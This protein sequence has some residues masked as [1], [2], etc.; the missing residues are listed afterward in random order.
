MWK[1]WIGW[2][3]RAFVFD[4]DGPGMTSPITNC[5]ETADQ[6]PKLKTEMVTLYTP[7][8]DWSFCHHP[9]ISFFDGRFYATWSN[10]FIHEDDY[11]QRMMF[12]TAE[13]FDQWSEPEVLAG[14]PPSKHG[15]EPA[16]L[17][18]AGM[19]VADGSLVAYYGLYD[20]VH[21]EFRYVEGKEHPDNLSTRDGTSLWARTTTDGEQWTEAADLNCPI[22][23]N[24]GPEKLQ[25]GRLIISGNTMFPYTDDPR[26][27]AGWT[28]AGIYPQEMAEGMIDEPLTFEKV[29]KKA[30][31]PVPLCE[32]SFYQ[33]DDGAITMM[34]RSTENR[35]WVSHSQDDGITWTT[36]APTNFTD[37]I[38]KMHFGR[39]P[40]G[41]FY[42][43]GC[44]DPEPGYTRRRL[45][46][47]LS[48]DGIVFD[49][50]YILADEPFE[51]ILP[52]RY[53]AGIYGYGHTM[54][55][56]D[57]CLYVIFSICKEQI[58][59][60]RTACELDIL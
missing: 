53:K 10:G 13:R 15:T 14:P 22:I 3:N 33:K 50:S 54:L 26:G 58:A 7:Q 60:V 25:S 4:G 1:F 5:Y 43:V 55:N 2:G 36:P 48:D 12:S 51:M 18:A 39:W 35:L 24:L 30:G 49:R 52:G 6:W 21:G 29:S 19:H 44:P 46:L 38:T 32:G 23:P 40:D 9:A 8:K 56:S 11:G 31:W 28:P 47:S 17:T 34:L 27:L 42:Y 45:V 57:G 20:I 59:A 16:I 41:R 37:N